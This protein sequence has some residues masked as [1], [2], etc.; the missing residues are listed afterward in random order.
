MK[1]PPDAVYHF[2]CD[3]CD[4]EQVLMV[5]HQ[6]HTSK[7]EAEIVI[8]AQDLAMPGGRILAMAE[9]GPW[10]TCQECSQSVPR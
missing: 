7:G 3:T 1:L 4:Q 10:T 8:P 9:S 6:V 5:W 2:I